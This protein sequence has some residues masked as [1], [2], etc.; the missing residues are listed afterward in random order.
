MMD[1][2]RRDL[3]K[4]VAVGTLGIGML[5]VMGK[6]ALATGSTLSPQREASMKNTPYVVKPLPFD[7]K[8]LHAISEKVIVSHWENNYSGAVKALN[9]VEQKL[10]EWLNDSNIPPYM[11]GD[12]KREQLI[13]K[14]SVV[15]HELY[16][17]NLGGDGQISGDISF[18]L[19]ESFGC[20]SQWSNEFKKTAMSLAGGS[21]W[22]TLAYDWHAGRLCNY[23]GWDHAHTAPMNAPLLVLDMYEHSFHMDYGAAAAKYVDAF[24]TNINW[25]EVDR[26]YVSY[27][28][29]LGS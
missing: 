19:D 20:F 5:G 14:G 21:G 18:A 27:R 29:G 23:W 28:K 12:L 2:N 9:L 8:T 11:Y 24:M 26:R 13:K 15:L 4:T 10:V 22:V 6:E 1:V 3:M 17:A 16:F 25:T 7:P